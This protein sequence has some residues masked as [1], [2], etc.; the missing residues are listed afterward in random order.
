MVAEESD[1]SMQWFHFFDDIFPGRWYRKGLTAKRTVIIRKA[2]SNSTHLRDSP[3]SACSQSHHARIGA[4][5]R[6]DLWPW[7]IVLAN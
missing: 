6:V 3:D 1:G 4:N 5:L 2:C 7:F